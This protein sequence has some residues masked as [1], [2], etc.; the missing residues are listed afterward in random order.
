MKEV[1]DDLRVLL[2]A[3]EVGTYYCNYFLPAGGA[4]PGNCVGFHI[5]V[6]ELIGVRVG[7]VRGQED[8]A[9][10]VRCKIKGGHGPKEVDTIVTQGKLG[11]ANN[12]R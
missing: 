8:I 6:E 11:T 10:K 12:L 3:A 9:L 1:F 2:C 7:A 4:A 5:V